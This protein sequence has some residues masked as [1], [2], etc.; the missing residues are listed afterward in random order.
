MTSKFQI[1]TDAQFD[2]HIDYD[3]EQDIVLYVNDE[4][5][6]ALRQEGILYLFEGVEDY[7]GLQ[8]ADNGT[9]KVETDS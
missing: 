2:V 9:I 6:L 8:L 3:E 4:P 1:R 5:I 7:L